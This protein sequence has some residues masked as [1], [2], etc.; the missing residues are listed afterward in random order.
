[1][2]SSSADLYDLFYAGKD[3]RAEAAVLAAVIRGRKVDAVTVLDVACGTGEHARHLATEHAFRVDGIDAERRLVEMASTK[4]PDGRFQCADMIDFRLGRVYDAVVCLFGSIGYVR[5]V[6]RLERA[7]ASMATH[8]ATP[9]VL[10]V[11]PWFEPGAMEDGY[12]TCMTVD[13]PR[14]KACRMTHT[15]ITGR[16]SRLQF[17]Y[18]IGSPEGLERTTEIHELG[19]FSRQE[20]EHAFAAAGLAVE[21]QADGLTGRGLYLAERASTH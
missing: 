3:Y 1:L 15:A 13:T 12:V 5:E 9:G 10:V 18:L 2:F 20:M 14:G 6:S 7:I 16:L 21:Y 11:E 8:M 19:L 4:H 17:E